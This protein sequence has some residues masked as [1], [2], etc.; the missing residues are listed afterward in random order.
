[1]AR[2]TANA[3]RPQKEGMMNSE[4]FIRLLN[5]LDAEEDGKL[6]PEESAKLDTYKLRDRNEQAGLTSDEREF[7]DGILERIN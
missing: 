3:A 1:M 5:V 7:V 6:T 4:Y 2:A